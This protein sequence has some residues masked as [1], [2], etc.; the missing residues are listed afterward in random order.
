MEF[1]VSMYLITAKP[2]VW[3]TF[4]DPKEAPVHWMKEMPWNKIKAIQNECQE[5]MRLWGYKIIFGMS[6]LMNSNTLLPLKL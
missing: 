5:A 2:E 4:R 3:N 1:S 6:D